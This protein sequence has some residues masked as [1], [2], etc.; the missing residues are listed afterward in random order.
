M[1]YREVCMLEVKEVLRPWLAGQAK[2]AIA[3]QVGSDPKTV[4]SYD[5]LFAETPGPSA[6]E[7]ERKSPGC[8]A[9]ECG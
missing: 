5:E 6:I 2:K 1:T 3:R 8:S 9:R 4:R 7:S